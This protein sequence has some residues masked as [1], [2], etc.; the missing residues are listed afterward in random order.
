MTCLQL[1]EMPSTEP[2]FGSR[3]AEFV[4]GRWITNSHGVAKTGETDRL[5]LHG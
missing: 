2:G 5:T 3:Q 1:G 4:R